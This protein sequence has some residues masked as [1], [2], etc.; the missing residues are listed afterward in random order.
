MLREK[1]LVSLHDSATTHFGVI[2]KC[3]LVNHAAKEISHPRYS[4]DL[5]PTYCSYSLKLKLP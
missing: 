4:L 1:Q 5:T 3:F 2:V